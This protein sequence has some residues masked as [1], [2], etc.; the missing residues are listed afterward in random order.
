MDGQKEEKK[1]CEGGG[2]G[3]IDKLME[4]RARDE[5]KRGVRGRIGFMSENDQC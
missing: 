3:G 5:G 2:G 1:V 4:R